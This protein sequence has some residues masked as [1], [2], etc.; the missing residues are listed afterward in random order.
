MY[1]ALS[2]LTHGVA[3]QLLAQAEAR[4]MDSQRIAEKVAQ[5]LNDK[6]EEEWRKLN[7]YG[8]RV[9]TSDCAEHRIA[10]V[11]GHEIRKMF[12]IP[13]EAYGYWSVRLGPECWQDTGR[14]GFLNW[15]LDKNPWCRTRE[16][17]DTQIVGG[18]DLKG[19][20]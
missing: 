6:M 16:V 7:A 2:V 12:S 15:F 1:T 20:A 11:D 10:K 14:E 18:I 4:G 13:E 3:A 9:R 17:R 19:G 8:A 5:R